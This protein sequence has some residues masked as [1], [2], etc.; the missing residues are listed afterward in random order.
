MGLLTWKVASILIKFVYLVLII[1]KGCCFFI[2]LSLTLLTY[3]SSSFIKLRTKACC[4]ALSPWNYLHIWVTS[5]LLIELI[6]APSP[7]SSIDS[8]IRFHVTV[9][10]R[11]SFLDQHLVFLRSLPL[12][13]CRTLSVLLLLRMLYVAVLIWS[14][15][16]LSGHLFLLELALIIFSGAMP[17]I[18]L[19][20]D[21]INFIR[22]A[23]ILSLLLVLSMI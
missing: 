18:I 11:S 16:V 13:A 8:S 3:F 6:I 1:L 14:L 15:A 2:F 19:I 4:L 5:V 22:D 23:D 9:V 21:L 7:I 17:L 20:E 12:V 10:S